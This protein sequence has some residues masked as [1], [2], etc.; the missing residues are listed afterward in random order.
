DRAARDADAA[1]RPRLGVAA[2]PLTDEKAEELGLKEAKGVVVVEVL[3]GT[4]AE[5]AG[6]KADDVILSVGGKA[7]E[8]PAGLVTVLREAKPGAEVDVVVVRAGKKTTLKGVKLAAPK[9]DG[10]KKPEKAKPEGDKKPAKEKAGGGADGQPLTL[11]LDIKPGEGVKPL[12]LRA[13]GRADGKPLTLVRPVG[14][15]PLAL[16]V[17]P[18][19]GKPL[20]LRVEGKPAAGGTKFDTTNIRINDGEFQ[21]DAKADGTAYRVKGSVE[22]GKAVP[23]EVRITAGDEKAAKYKSLEEVPAE[24]RAAVKQLLAGISGGGR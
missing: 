15:K 9:G 1:R 12:A 7:V 16:E 23:S 2:E 10:D 21:I 18:A 22:G 24:H 11:E 6:V 8:D 5:K 14:G 13:E 4:P 20:A 17:K 19:D 3:K